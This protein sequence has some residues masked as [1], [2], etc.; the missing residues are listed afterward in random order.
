MLSGSVVQNC[1][2]VVNKG[3]EKD[4][5]YLTR[6][7]SASG[8]Y[9]ASNYKGLMFGQGGS[10]LKYGKAYFTGDV[11]LRNCTT[12]DGKPAPALVNDGETEI[13]DT[14]V[15]IDG[16]ENA[17]GNINYAKGHFRG[18]EAN[19]TEGYTATGVGRVEFST[20][21]TFVMAAISTQLCCNLPPKEVT[22][23]SQTYDFTGWYN[24]TTKY[25]FS[26]AIRQY[27]DTLYLNAGLKPKDTG[28]AMPVPTEGGLVA[29]LV[30]GNEKIQLT[31]DITLTKTLEI[32][33]L[34]VTLDLNGYVLKGDLKQLNN[35]TLT[36][37]DSRPTATHGSDASLPKGGVI[38]GN[39]IM[40]HDGKY[41]PCT[42]VGN[43]GSIVGSVG[44]DTGG[45]TIKNTNTL[46]VTHFYGMVQSYGRVEG[47]IYYGGLKPYAG[48][49]NP[50]I[51][52]QTVTFQSLP[53]TTYAIGVYPSGAAQR[54]P[55]NPTRP[56]YTFGSWL[57]GSSAYTFAGSNEDH[58]VTATWFCSHT[59]VTHV[60][61]QPSTCTEHGWP[62]YDY[63]NNCGIYRYQI[64]DLQYTSDKKPQRDLASH[65]STDSNCATCL[66]RAICDNCHRPYG[67][68]TRHDF[69]GEYTWNENFCLRKC[70]TEGCTQKFQIGLHAFDDDADA[71]CNRCGYIR[72][73]EGAV[74]THNWGSGWS[75]NATH[76]WHTCSAEGCTETDVSKMDGYALHS[77]GADGKCICGAEH[78]HNWSSTWEKNGTHHWHACTANG[79]TVTEP[80]EM[81]SYAAH[82][83]DAD[84]KCDC[85]ATHA[86]NW[87]GSWASN[88][89]HHWH[90]CTVSGCYLT[91]SADMDGYAAHE[92]DAD[93]NC[94]C[95][96]VRPN[97]Q[98]PSSSYT[99][100]YAP[101][102]NAKETASQTDTK[103]PGEALTLK[104][105]IFT[106]EG[107]AQDGW[108]TLNGDGSYVYAYSLGDGYTEDADVTLY[109]A[110]VKVVTLEI[111]F[112]IQVGKGGSATPPAKTFELEMLESKELGPGSASV[113]ISGFSLSTSG[114]GSY[115]GT[116]TFTGAS[117]DINSICAGC[118]IRQKTGSDAGWT[119][120]PQVW[121]I[122]LRGYFDTD[123]SFYGASPLESGG[124]A[125]ET[126]P[127]VYIS[128]MVWIPPQEHES[129]EIE[130][131]R[132]EPEDPDDYTSYP[133]VYSNSYKGYTV[134][135]NAN[136]GTVVTTGA[137]LTAP[138]DALIT[139]PTAAPQKDADEN[140]TYTFDGWYTEATGGDKVTFGTLKLTGDKTY[141]AHYTPTTRKY[142]VTVTNG[143]GGGSYAAAAAV[144]IQAN[145]PESG[146]RFIGW[147][148][149]SGLTITSGSNTTQSVTFTMPARDVQATALYENIQNPNPPATGFT[150]TFHANGGSGEMDPATNVSGTY[151]LP[152]TTTFTAP[153][154]KRFKGW[155][156]SA[157]GAVITSTTINV[158]G[159]KNLYAIWESDGQNPNPPATKYKVIVETDGNGTASATPSTDIAAGTRVTLTADANRGFRLKEWQILSG[160]VTITNNQFMMPAG[161][162]KLK[163]VFERILTPGSNPNSKPA[164]Q[165]GS[166]VPN[167]LNSKDHIAYVQ[168]YMDGTVR[169]NAPITRAETAMML[170]RL[171][172]DARRDEIETKRHNYTDIPADAWY[173]MAVA[174]MTNGG[175]I[176]GYAD[177]TF[178]G[179]RNITRAEFI[180]ILVRFIGIRNARC[181][182][183]DV[184]RDHWA[185]RCIAAAA[186]AGWI[187][188]GADGAFRPDDAI[189]RAEAMAII[190][191]V[192]ERGVDENSE[193]PDFHRFSDNVPGKWYYYEVIEA[194]NG[195]DYTGCRPSEDWTAL[196][197]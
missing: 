86:H 180:A 116:L 118:L 194:S 155:A 196:H 93:G 70:K 189:T 56:G 153:T 161:D 37:I 127:N 46:A 166:S 54:R 53:G 35:S 159:D 1:R 121:S 43:G 158:T 105:A 114:T 149:L 175:Y 167:G 6:T 139:P 171:L 192:L 2:G 25:T 12:L 129:G 174:T 111:P 183:T 145:A 62:A 123:G 33:N 133:M 79:C 52:G 14:R 186:E 168:G 119:Y 179:D 3:T 16:I 132:Y 131:G 162:V 50:I 51:Y 29:A 113:M 140:Y 95:G 101:G 100:T 193:L 99:V 190:N 92:F 176:T 13:L 120:D 26:D 32:K 49:T 74:H 106:R 63:C 184:S 77:Y 18:Y 85:G 19:V 34:N 98:I 96:A 82:S 109:P 78:E 23:T 17:T 182:F 5:I 94:V 9:V 90:V 173:R 88:S 104:D 91:S 187:T 61:A 169:P 38:K 126:E 163:A 154:G 66:R 10:K 148:G 146:K 135:W 75:K 76:H 31:R 178:G 197:K 160:G 185:Y 181:S 28:K 165:E 103:T 89:S 110:W 15:R 71:E 42:L 157:N 45:A 97:E 117:Y 65:T 27:D 73:V 41:A 64:G 177:G 7:T 137:T 58:T 30:A 4:Q 151:T 138:V 195:H 21:G 8:V 20:N 80:S 188:G 57:E 191:R 128:K 69:T 36:L 136:G 59:D 24:G 11:K 83:F 143:T 39:I 164:R 107:Y 147:Q 84:G 67:T 108:C 172:T 170:Y 142:T 130:P 112:T 134:T 102:P 124:S 122:E 144:S 47:G 150:V 141:Y 156:E 87:S 125:G 152:T 72:S 115:S 81:D 55:V 60:D 68:T 44:M 22:I 40:T 48:H